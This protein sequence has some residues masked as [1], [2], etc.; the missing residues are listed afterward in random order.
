MDWNDTAADGS[1]A[2]SG[3]G[4]S[5]LFSKPSWQTGTG[6]P[7]DGQRDVPDLALNSSAD[8]DGYLICS[9]SS[10]VNWLTEGPTR[11]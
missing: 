4:V 8:H 6:V 10:C 5:T 9:R 11:R 2:A 7:A 1:L 3:G